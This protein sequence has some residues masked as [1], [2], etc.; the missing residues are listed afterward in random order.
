VRVLDFA[1]SGFGTAEDLIV[2]Q[3][4]VAP[5]RPDV[6]IMS[7]HASDPA[8]NIRSALFRV[9]NGQAVATGN[10]FLPG[11][12]VS[13][14]LMRF[15]AYRWLIENSHFYS[16]VR[17]RAGRF[18]KNVLASVRSYGRASAALPPLVEPDPV[19]I[20]MP[21]R[22]P[23]MGDP[24]LDLALLRASRDTAAAMGAQFL[25]FD[26]P[27]YSSRTR[28]VSP[29]AL[30]LGDLPGINSVS[31]IEAFYAV[32]SPDQKLYLEQGQLHWTALGNAV[33]AE[34]AAADIIRRG[35]LSGCGASAA[36]AKSFEKSAVAP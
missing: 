6:V 27:I 11:V 9:E 35:W 22:D 1:V 24:A 30:Y 10:S 33:A 8:D 32:A 14:G 2:L 5:W 34:V 31:A 21:V 13:D 15:A 20:G 29:Q 19:A 7:W 18:T 3:K 17:E 23:P 16:A 26:I 25:L 4:R 36:G 28:F 12:S